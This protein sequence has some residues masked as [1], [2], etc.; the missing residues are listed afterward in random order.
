MFEFLCALAGAELAWAKAAYN[1]GSFGF[2][3]LGES[4]LFR[5]EC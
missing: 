5:G 3:S 4:V 2:Q 1:S